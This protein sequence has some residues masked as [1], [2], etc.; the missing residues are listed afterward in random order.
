ML[1]IPS[2][3]LTAQK[4][5]KLIAARDR[6]SDLLASAAWLEAEGRLGHLVSALE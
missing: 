5:M 3:C 6:D 4:G 1:S 2:P